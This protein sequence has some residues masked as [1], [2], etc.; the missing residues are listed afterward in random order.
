MEGDGGGGAALRNLIH[1]SFFP[2]NNFYFKFIR[3]LCENSLDEKPRGE[4]IEKQYLS[5][6]I[7][8]IRANIHILCRAYLVFERESERGRSAKL[9]LFSGSN[10]SSF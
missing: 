5:S 2:I 8:F 1:I 6:F 3:C 7:P 9:Y 10:S 4:D